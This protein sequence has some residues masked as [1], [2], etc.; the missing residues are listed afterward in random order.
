MRNLAIEYKNPDQFETAGRE[1]LANPEL[2]VAVVRNVLRD[3][4]VRG[5]RALGDF[6][7]QVEFIRQTVPGFSDLEEYVESWYGHN[8]YNDYKMAP[9]GAR[10]GSIS[11]ADRDFVH[12]DP[13][14][15][16]GT[17]VGY[18]GGLTFS[19]CGGNSPK[20]Y[21]IY[22]AARPTRP[23]SDTEGNLDHKRYKSWARMARVTSYMGQT[24]RQ[25][26]GDVAMFVQHPTPSAHR[27]ESFNGRTARVLDFPIVSTSS[28]A[29]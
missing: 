7:N 10:I 20:S 14:H 18:A 1:L 29:A 12:V 15:R 13:E 25:N 9:G 26:Y 8:G 19:F 22:R 3:N 24:I 27:V 16:W 17:I 4:E 23:L 28:E 6:D 5:V 11:K 21:A 2:S